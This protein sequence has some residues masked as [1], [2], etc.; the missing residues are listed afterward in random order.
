M[1]CIR[2]WPRPALLLS[3]IEI[4]AAEHLGRIS[5]GTYCCPSRSTLP[6]KHWLQPVPHMPISTDTLIKHIDA[7]IAARS[8]HSDLIGGGRKLFLEHVR[9]LISRYGLPLP[10]DCKLDACVMPYIF[11]ELNY[12]GYDWASRNEDFG[13]LSDL[14]D[15]DII[16]W[17]AG[18]I[19]S[20]LSDKEF[21]DYHR[22][23]HDAI[24]FRSRG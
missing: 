12:D 15:I 2:T 1:C 17:S 24:T 3:K 9:E 22:F 16:T 10:D 19:R 4:A 5:V 14:V 23:C 6:I 21:A 11:Q 20:E 7:A 18:R 13:H 8:S